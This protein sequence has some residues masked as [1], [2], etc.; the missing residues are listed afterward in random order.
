M[1]LPDGKPPGG[2]W[3][4]EPLAELVRVLL[5]AAGDPRGRPR[6]VAVD[7]RSSSGK[8]TLVRRLEAAVPGAGA[9][10]ADDVARAHAAFDWADLLA[11]GVLEPARRGEP[12]AFRPPAWA[13]RGRGGAV[14]EGGP[15]RRQPAG[16]LHRHLQPHPGRGPG[17]P[18]RG[19]HLVHRI[20]A[21][22]RRPRIAAIRPPRPAVDVVARTA[23]S[24]LGDHGQLSCSDPGCEPLP[25]RHRVDQVGVVQL[26]RRRRGEHTGPRRPARHVLEHAY[27]STGPDR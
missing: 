5:A 7:G 4:V 2:P 15:R 8:T 27:D 6:I 9:V 12:V 14:A 26:R 25:C 23:P 17:Q 21:D 22:L 19:G 20:L 3:R 1:R 18:Q 10:H 13:A 16:E 11:G 24:E